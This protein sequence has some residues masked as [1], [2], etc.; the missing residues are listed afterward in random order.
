MGLLSTVTQLFKADVGPY[1]QK[2]K[3][4][5]KV[6]RDSVKKQIADIDAQNAKLEQQIAKIG[7]VT[8]A[9]GAVVG[10]WKAVSASFEAY[11]HRA[12]QR[13]A[14][15]GT[16]VA[17]LQR[18]FKGL[19]G[20]TR[21]LEFAAGA[22]NG[23]FKVTQEQMEMAGKAV[24]ALRNQGNDLN[25]V[26]DDVQKAL[27]EGN[28]RALLKYGVNVTGATGSTE[29]FQNVLKALQEQANS[30]FASMENGADAMRRSMVAMRD[31]VDDIKESIGAAVAATARWVV[32]MDRLTGGS[33]MDSARLALR[34]KQ[35]GGS[36]AL[37][38]ELVGGAQGAFGRE[39]IR[40]QA[41][42]FVGSFW[43]T[44]GG[45]SR[46][47]GKGGGAA[48]DVVELIDEQ[49]GLIINART[50]QILGI[51]GAEAGVGLMDSG[52][53]RAFGMGALP[54]LPSTMIT[55][56][57]GF[58][59]LLGDT[60]KGF[61]KMGRQG[62][63]MRLEQIFG[64]VDQ[65][66]VYASAFRTLETAAASAFLAWRSGAESTT[67]ALERV[68][69][70][71]TGA[72]ADEFFMQAVRHGAHAVGQ[73]A[74]GL[75]GDPRAM[76][77]AK[78]HGLAAAKFGAGALLLGGASRVMADGGGGAGAG[79][80]GSSIGGGRG[81]GGGGGG[82]VVINQYIGNDFSDQNP[83]RRASQLHRM[84]ERGRRAAG[85]TGAVRRP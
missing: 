25:S 51:L 43:D 39:R 77:A 73:L 1:K 29:A 28:G 36:Q 3:E 56:R 67:E 15:H 55:G 12:Q 50:G 27:V 84:A 75:A 80:S 65:F 22:M 62:Q 48:A 37:I 63:D 16:D 68:V 71:M 64:P 74:F 10:A 72:L 2:L 20:E 14:A 35:A 49:L 60:A 83:R 61:G 47:K 44:A 17:R 82:P 40:A 58:G 69:E 31:I 66:D 53:A 41:R 26:L 45:T 8:L 18:S 33:A 9:I 59:G 78:V 34:A 85:E 42:G 32:E 79:L 52:P 21:S 46:P 81:G 19:V 7:K 6:H 76:A 70:T 38:A 57:G 13:M 4:V 24:I 11:E 30:D 5:E 54:S 23:A